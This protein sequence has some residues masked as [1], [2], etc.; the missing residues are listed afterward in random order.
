MRAKAPESF[1]AGCLPKSKER[2]LHTG[3]TRF[4][5]AYRQVKRR[6]I[7]CAKTKNICRNAG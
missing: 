5:E 3:L 7:C 1:C 2:M 6:C 4:R